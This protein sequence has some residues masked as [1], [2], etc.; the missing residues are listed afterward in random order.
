MRELYRCFDPGL[1]SG[2]CDVY[3]HEMPGGQYTNLLFQSR[4]LGLG[5]Q[6]P[7]IK[8]AY[9]EANQLMGDVVKVT[10]S[11]KVCGDL[12]QFMVQNKLTGADVR[13]QADKLNFPQSVV[14]YFQGY[15]GVPPGGFDE[16][17][18]AQIVKNLPTITGRPGAELPALDIGQLRNDLKDKYGVWITKYDVM[19]SAMYP[20]VFDDFASFFNTYGDVS[21]LDTQMFLKPLEVGRE[22]SVELEMGKTLFIKLVTVS[23][24][25]SSAGCRDVFFE[26]NGTPRRIVVSDLSSK[27]TSVARPKA[28]VSKKGEVGAPMSGAVVEIRVREGHAVMEGDPICVLNAMK[29]ETVVGATATG[30]LSSLKVSV[31]D[32][33]SAGDLVAVIT[34]GGSPPRPGKKA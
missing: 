29:M 11:S 19:S 32:S 16:K 15:L 14:M 1:K 12:A 27:V 13:A 7:A 5:D 31:G 30:I 28:D 26:L 4:S 8:R 9:A 21:V 18:R 3:L 23:R 17:L 34:P 6:W 20:K 24:Q 22:Y 10:P 2:S 33:I 25:A